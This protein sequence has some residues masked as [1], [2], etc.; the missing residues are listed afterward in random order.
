MAAYTSHSLRS[1]LILSIWL[2]IEIQSGCAG[3]TKPSQDVQSWNMADQ[4]LRNQNPSTMRMFRRN[5]YSE[6]SDGATDHY[7][8]LKR[9]FYA[10]AGKRSSAPRFYQWAGK[11]NDD[12]SDEKVRRKFYAW[13]G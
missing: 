7:E 2:S 10:W 5:E 3:S 11:R 13:A 6:D 8:L 4:F 1:V 9:K 12:V